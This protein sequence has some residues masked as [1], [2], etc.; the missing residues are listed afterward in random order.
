MSLV[1][2]PSRMNG[3]CFRYGSIYSCFGKGWAIRHFLDPSLL[4]CPQELNEENVVLSRLKAESTLLQDAIEAA[5]LITVASQIIPTDG[6]EIWL[7]VTPRVPVPGGV[8]HVGATLGYR[9]ISDLLAERLSHLQPLRL[10]AH[11]PVHKYLECD[12]NHR[13]CFYSV[14]ESYWGWMVLD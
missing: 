7:N 1:W 5:K 2:S 6:M 14:L 3:E 12:S 4:T 13:E 8:Q 11:V 10:D 9:C